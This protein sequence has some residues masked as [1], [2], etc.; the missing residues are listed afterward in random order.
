MIK[1][2][3]GKSVGALVLSLSLVC[4]AGLSVF[5]VDKSQISD[6]DTEMS[7]LPRG[8]RTILN[9]KLNNFSLRLNL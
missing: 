6:M 7:K 5:A 8:C 2:R 9:T 1:D 3:V 4:T